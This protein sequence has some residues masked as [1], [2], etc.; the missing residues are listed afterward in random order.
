LKFANAIPVSNKSASAEIVSQVGNGFG[1][2]GAFGLNGRII[3]FEVRAV[4]VIVNVVDPPAVT[5]DGLNVATAPSGSPDAEKLTVAGKVPA[6]AVVVNPNDADPPAVTVCVVAVL[7]KV[8]SVTLNVV[9][10][11]V[12]PPGAGFTTVIV[13]AP[14]VEISDVVTAAVSCVALMNVVVSEV[15][16]NFTTEPFTKFVPFTVNMKAAPPVIADVGESVVIVGT[17]SPTVSVVTEVDDGANPLVLV[18][19]A[20]TECAPA[21]KPVSVVVATPFT[22]LTEVVVVSTV[23][24]TVPVGVI[25][26]PETVALTVTDWPTIGAAGT[27]GPS[28]VVDGGAT[29][30]PAINNC[31][32]AGVESDAFVRL[33]LNVA[34]SVGPEKVVGVNEA[35]SAQTPPTATADGKVPMT[36]QSVEAAADKPKSVESVW[37]TEVSCAA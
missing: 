34:V 19:A 5:V 2:L 30:G 22:K 32:D 36:V 12:P 4:V 1:A 24:T 25:P 13:A 14:P 9:P 35:V 7:L 20:E 15:V 8:K 11:D 6:T 16:L 37:L 29:D 26:A 27:N 33:P 18:Y 23:N 31:T 21:V 17:S 10:A 3:A 28:T